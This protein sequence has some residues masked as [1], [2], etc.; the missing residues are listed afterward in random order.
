MDKKFLYFITEEDG[1][2]RQV[3]NGNVVSLITKK[4]LPNAPIGNQ[5]ISIGWERNRKYWGV[6]RNFSL[7]MGF[8]RDGYKILSNDY[9]KFNIDRKLFL[10]LYRFTSDIDALNFTDYYKFLY[11]GQL[12]FS[13]AKDHQGDKI[14]EINI[15]EGGLKR[16]MN[17]NENTE[18]TIPFDEDAVNVNNDGM[19]IDYKSEFLIDPGSSTDPAFYFKN[20]I[21]GLNLIQAESGFSGGTQPVERQQVNPDAG[22]LHANG[23]HFF[24]SSVNGQVVINYNLSLNVE[25]TPSSPAI[26][27]AAIYRVGFERVDKTGAFISLD[28]VLS[29]SA[30]AG[31]PGNYNVSGTLTIPINKDDELY[32]VAFC[33]VEGA[34][35]D[36]Q[37]RTTYNITDDPTI[38]MSYHYRNDSYV[39]KGFTVYDLARKLVERITG[40]AN[41]FSS[42]F[43]QSVNIVLTSG[44]GVRGVDGAGVKT[45]W[46]KLFNFIDC[47]KMAEMTI[48]DTSIIIDQRQAAFNT[49]ATV[50]NLGQAKNLTVSTALELMA[51]SIKVG[52]AEQQVDDV[53]GKYDFNGYDTFGLPI[54]SIEGVELNLQHDYKA[55]PYEIELTR[56]NYQ[57]KTTTDKSTDNNIFALAVLA[58][59]NSF[60]SELSFFADGTPFAPGKPMI[61]I[62]STVSVLLRAGM[63]IQVAGTASNDGIYTVASVGVWFFGQLVVTNEPLIDEAGV[64]GVTITILKGLYYDLDRTIPVTQLVSVDDVDADIKASIY[65]VPLTPK[66]MLMQHYRWLAGMLHKYSGKVTF[67]GANRN[68]DL[69]A[70]GII[71]AADV[72][73]TDLGA[74]LW[75]PF[76]MELTVQV[77]INLVEVL[78]ND[79]ASIFRFDWENK[80]W[81]GFLLTAG[82]SPHTEKEQTFLLLMTP[83][84]N[85]EDF[86]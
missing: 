30:G 14:F 49:S 84:N 53:N 72:N 51:T 68:K 83:N 61:S 79:P 50:V 75:L 43:L 24:K 16:Q 6:V 33:T 8:V 26:N 29:R 62:P 57:D 34:S 12:D 35:G 85:P 42:T 86:I 15:M 55:S 66:R 71:E 13:N 25:Y 28:A 74:P 4:P 80:T 2:V 46:G 59:T 21:I 60:T 73:I 31:I 10:Q 5:E 56:A 52:H 19:I 18:F 40:S 47:M 54:E 36:A 70:G 20:H 78:Q 9:Y 67:G 44:D 64:A 77:P 81:E 38:K 27:P 76:F 58:A 22:D 37:I 23:S 1:R 63:M 17:A 69:I 41:N 82:L 39:I 7:P 65:N 3:V 32:L 45:T 48:T 11:K